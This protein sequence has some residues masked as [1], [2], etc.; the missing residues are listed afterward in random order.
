[1]SVSVTRTGTVN[2]SVTVQPA[3]VNVNVQAQAR[4]K[5]YRSGT[6]LAN[7]TEQVVV[8]YVGV[9]RLMGYIDMQ[10]LGSGEEVVIRQYMK[11]K[12]DGDYKKYEEEV[13][14]GPLDPPV[15][16]VT[17]KESDFGIKVTLQ[18]ISGTYRSFDYN[19]LVEI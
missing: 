3:S 12:P 11:L 19:F 7:G 1:M 8:E 14:T 17:P 15:V 16:Y 4:L 13:Y 18:Q 9:G 6:I 2:V 10:N 5:P